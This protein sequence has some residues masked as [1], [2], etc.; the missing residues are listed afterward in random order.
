[1]LCRASDICLRLFADCVRAAASRTFWTAG[2]SSPIRI[3]MMAITTSSSMRVKARPDFKSRNR[4]IGTPP[5]Q[6]LEVQPEQAGG[7]SLG[8]AEVA[9]GQGVLALAVEP[10]ENACGAVPA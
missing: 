5:E 8:Q 9:A 4:G 3:A 6:G 10:G 2:T 7:G 1:M